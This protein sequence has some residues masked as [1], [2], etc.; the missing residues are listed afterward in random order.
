M[1]MLVKMTTYAKHPRFTRADYQLEPPLAH[2][3]QT[4]RTTGRSPIEGHQIL[5]FSLGLSKGVNLKL[6]G[7]VFAL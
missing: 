5:G 1:S 4:L 6:A 3:L 7:L 2:H